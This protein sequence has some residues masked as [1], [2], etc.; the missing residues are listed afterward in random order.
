MS[1]VT[2]SSG[3]A[4]A[5]D[6]DD[7]RA[8]A[9]DLDV[10]TAQVR[11][12]AADVSRAR[13]RIAVALFSA[14]GEHAEAIRGVERLE[15]AAADAMALAAGLRTSADA[16][17]LIELRLQRSAAGADTAAVDAEIALRR[18]R[19]PEA[20][21]IA[22]AA[23]EEHGHAGDAAT[24]QLGLLRTV[25]L[26]TGVAAPLAVASGALAALVT[27][28]R[29]SGRGRIPRGGAV[30]GDVGP[31]AVRTVSTASAVAPTT[32]ADAF[33]RIPEG[34]D[35]RVRVE[36]YDLPDGRRA[37]A[38]YV[39]GMQTILGSD[40]WNGDA[41]RRL[42][43]GEDAASLAA[44]EAALAAAGAESGDALF[45]F[46]HSQGG[47][48][49]DALA[50]SGVYD[51]QVLA[52]AGSP[53]SYDAGPGTLSAEL[54]HGDDPVSALAD[55]GYPQ[56]VGGEGSFVAERTAD[57]DVGI[58]DLRAAA[59]DLDAYLETA[60]MVDGSGDPRAA[61]LHER[62]GTLGTATAVTA[63]EFA[64]VAAPARHPVPAPGPAPLTP[65]AG[66]AG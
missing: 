37:F 21:R 9:A 66:G 38:V 63:Y 40:P 46:G 52:T 27:G 28:V 58:Q 31:V 14:L 42:F 33:D 13:E 43:T 36:R 5:V 1:G 57:P 61:A 11:E 51:T 48:I 45:A 30:A 56:R 41:N 24:S 26:L 32:L 44:V 65:S 16:Y 50:A 20:E 35:A 47:M 53:T 23:L 39:V 55:G 25:A 3:G 15:G 12:A 22:E 19:S 59:H 4:I 29:S 64:P 6:A 60:A 7:L 54:R 49:V 10:A 34:G 62:L 8:A 2:I 18:E 17:D